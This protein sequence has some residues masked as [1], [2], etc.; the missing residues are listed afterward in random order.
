MC[1]GT[2]NPA[3]GKLAPGPLTPEA[4]TLSM[5]GAQLYF[6]Q[7]PDEMDFFDPEGSTR[8]PAL[9]WRTESSDYFLQQDF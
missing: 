5:P 8:D 9:V 6:V 3:T 2:C 1:W 4:R 7:A